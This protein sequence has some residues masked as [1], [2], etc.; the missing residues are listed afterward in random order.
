M[1]HLAT[2]EAQHLNSRQL[3]FALRDVGV[4]QRKYHHK[5]QARRHKG[6]KHHDRID[7]RKVCLIVFPMLGGARQRNPTIALKTVG[8]RN[9]VSRRTLKQHK[10]AVKACTSTERALIGALRHVKRVA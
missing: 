4:R 8:K 1:V 7:N 3:A 10:D 6:H 5:R 2:T 9:L